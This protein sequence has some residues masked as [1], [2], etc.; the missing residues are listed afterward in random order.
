MTHKCIKKKRH[1]QQGKYPA[2]PLDCRN[3]L[4]G[5]TDINTMPGIILG[6]AAPQGILSFFCG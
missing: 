2:P 6:K 4:R 5:R 3:P 1:S